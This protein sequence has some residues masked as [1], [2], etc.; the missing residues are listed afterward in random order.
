MRCIIIGLLLCIV[1][2]PPVIR[3]E[4]IHVP[5]D[6]PDI[7]EGIDLAGTGDT[8]LVAPGIYRGVGNRDISFRGKAVTVESES[9]PLETIIDCGALGRGFR[10]NMHEVETSVLIG[11]TIRH[12]VS[13]DTSMSGGAI[14]CEQS[15]P[16]IQDCIFESN[17]SINYGGA[18]HCSAADPCINNCVATNNIA[19]RSGGGFSLDLESSPWIV[20]TLMLDNYAEY[21]G[22]AIYTN[23]SPFLMVNCTLTGNDTAGNGDGIYTFH[24]LSPTIVNSIIWNNDLE[25]IYATDLCGGPFVPEVSYSDIQYGYTGTGNI[26]ADP[27][28]VP[29]AAGDQYLSHTAAG[30]SDDSPCIDTGGDPASNVCFGPLS[31]EQCLDE[32][33]TRTDEIFDTGTVDMGYHHTFSG[34]VPPTPRPPAILRVPQDYFTIQDALDAAV[35]DGD[36]VLLAPGTYMGP[37]N[38]D[39][40]IGGRSLTLQSETG[41]DQCVIDCENQGRGIF[42][43]FREDPETVI[44]GLTIINGN[45]S[46]NGYD[47][48]GGGIL[49]VG[50]AP[51]IYN[52]SLRNNTASSTG[53]GIFISYE[54]PIISHCRFSENTAYMGGGLGLN[55]AHVS[56]E[57]CLFEGNA[58]GYSGGAMYCVYSDPAINNCTT[59]NNTAGPNGDGGGMYIGEYSS[60]TL[61]RSI[62]WDNSPDGL[63][64]TYCGGTVTVNYSDIQDGFA[65][66]GNIDMDPLFVIG[67][68][69]DFYL[70]QVAAGESTDSPCVNTGGIYAQDIPIPVPGG[71][72]RLDGFVTRTDD[73]PDDGIV[74]MG[75]HAFPLI[76]PTPT[77]APGNTPSPPPTFTPVI[78]PTH[79]PPVFSPTVTMTP[80]PSPATPT[81]AVQLGVTLDMPVYI[82]PGEPF[83]VTGI[84]TN[85]VEPMTDIP[86]IFAVQ[87]YDTLYFW[88]SWSTYHL[89]AGG[90]IDFIIR[91][92]STGTTLIPV[93]PEMLWPDT[94][95]DTL[96]HLLFYGAMLT[97][98]MQA[99]LGEM[100]TV[101]WGFGPAD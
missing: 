48:N 53:G 64:S 46:G 97:P 90:D 54:N 16:T 19:R 34:T 27:L 3:S 85:H 71:F 51:F 61:N 57:N 47:R 37:G 99:I 75:Y 59:R 14:Y 40:V 15:S 21:S 2:F 101:D 82:S 94:G 91:D 44:S 86:L 62:I 78:T 28:F 29:G 39:L 55:T 31:E 96:S 63:Y 25:P 13:M 88:P 23:D 70:S 43:I 50:S 65:G 41:P 95:E 9:G 49:C 79:T 52:C 5:G 67:S 87:I 76:Y 100:D 68:R 74:D 35:I 26:D 45:A 36:T 80:S 33:T 93:I 56:M 6:A 10:F 72:I 60:P 73:F 1:L 84:I 81:S 7:Q 4:I 18:I 17:F 20:N 22:G 42:M 77:V 66:T 83:H 11:F 92:I 58:A 24:E 32:L 89:S 69:G 12:G 38:R 8:V 30:Q 98:D